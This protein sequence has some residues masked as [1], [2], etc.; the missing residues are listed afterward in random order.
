VFIRNAGTSVINSNEIAILTNGQ[1]AMILNPQNISPQGTV[2]LRFIPLE[3]GSIDVKVQGPSNVVN[4]DADFPIY[5]MQ[6]L[7][8]GD[9]DYIGAT[10]WPAQMTLFTTDSHSGGN[11]SI[12]TDRNTIISTDY[13]P[14]EDYNDNVSIEFFAKSVGSSGL[15]S[16]LY[17]G[18]VGYDKDKNVIN[19]N[20][21]QYFAN[22]DTTLAAD[23]RPGDT[24]VQLTSGA[25]WRNYSGNPWYYRTIGFWNTGDYPDH[26]YT[27][28]LGYYNIT[29]G[30]TLILC[31]YSSCNVPA[32]WTGPMIPAGTAVANMYGSSN[33]SYAVGI[34][35][36][37]D[38]P[39]AW[40]NYNGTANG[41]NYGP[42]ISRRELRYGTKYIRV[43]FLANYGQNSTFSTLFDD[44]KVRITDG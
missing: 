25:N 15:E 1:P 18:F 36:P 8:N 40:T 33:Y 26:T 28:T 3:Y 35:S 21:V 22:T 38:V 10:G 39:T 14:Y 43:V 13:I 32:P 4:Y 2:M 9:F 20:N 11:S 7:V 29:A 34:T 19:L 23:L 24:E 6:N 44:I 17:A 27:R 30:N 41:W 37:S 16:R 31:S 5:I 42:S 12:V